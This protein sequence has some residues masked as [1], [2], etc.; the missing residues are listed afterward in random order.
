VHYAVTL[1]AAVSIVALV[2][3]IGSGH[4][5]RLVRYLGGNEPVNIAQMVR[6][7]RELSTPGAASLFEFVVLYLAVPAALVGPPTI[8][9]GLS[10]P[11][12]QRATQVDFARVGRRVG[13]LLFSNIAGSTAGAMAAGWVFLPVLGTAGTLRTLVGMGALLAVPFAFVR[14]ARAPRQ[15]VVTLAAVIATGIAVLTI[16][17]AETLWARLHGTETRQVLFAEDG[18]GLFLLKAGGSDFSSDITVFVNG[19]SQS[20]IPYGQGHTVLGALPTFIHPAPV[21]VAIIGL[22]SGDTA[23][24]AVG[25]AEVR[26]LVCVEIIGAQL[27]LLTRLA[28]AE[29][30]DGLLKLVTDRRIDHVV[31]DGRAYLARSA[32]LFDV[33]EADA[34]RPTSAYAGN[35]YSREYFALLRRRLKPGGLAVTWA[36]TERIRRTFVNV[37]PYVLGLDEIYIG[38][39]A[40]IPFQPSIVAERAA[41][42]RSY[43]AAAGIDIEALVRPYLEIPP[44]LFGPDFDRSGVGDLNTDTFPRDEFDLE[45]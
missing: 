6:L 9:M 12:L 17:D 16:P 11:L 19:L 43:Y 33:I 40:P 7:F 21:D 36:P 24:A 23:V 37:F 10:F 30:Y 35:L 26:R 31:G 20:S 5:V 18:S 34:L 41:S 29:S 38:S 14:W 45:F 22:G 27:G 28:R 2:G 44:R 4:P 1:Y 13:T 32:R 15:V 39:D 8:L 3:L 25:R 42:V